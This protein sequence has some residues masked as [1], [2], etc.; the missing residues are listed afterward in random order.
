MSR[1]S[2]TRMKRQIA[3]KVPMAIPKMKLPTP[4]MFQRAIAGFPAFV[5]E[6]FRDLAPSMK[7]LCSALEFPA[8]EFLP[9]RQVG[10]G[11]ALIPY[12]FRHSSD[13]RSQSDQRLRQIEIEQADIRGGGP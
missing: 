9:L 6:G 8:D 3:A 1:A 5:A 7:F 10:K 11:D 12:T 13:S 2:K 4:I